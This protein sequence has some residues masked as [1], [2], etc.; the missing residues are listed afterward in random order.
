MATQPDT[1]ANAL[2]DDEYDSSADEDFA[3]SDANDSPSSD[4]ENDEQ[5]PDTRTKKR[6]TQPAKTEIELDSGDEVTIKKGRK[7]RRKRGEGDI[8][9]DDEGGEGGLI[10]TR[11][12][13]AVE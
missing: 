10:K 5:A 3:A 4:S 13:R 11:A 12:Q 7:K 8:L 9:E 2:E 1:V 6:K